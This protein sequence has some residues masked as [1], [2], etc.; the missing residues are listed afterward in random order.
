MQRRNESWFELSESPLGIRANILWNTL[1]NFIYL[2]SQWFLTFCVVAVLGIENMGVFSLAIAITGAVIGISF[3]GVRSFQVSDVKGKYLDQV[4]VL[5]RIIT[6]A[7]SLV[8]CAVFVA[9]NAYSLYVSVC[10]LVYMLFKISESLSDVYQGVFQKTMRMD[11]IGKSFIIKGIAILLLFLATIYL[12]QDLLLGVVALCLCSCV[13]IALYDMRYA[14]KFIQTI[15]ET[16]WVSPTKALLIECLPIAGYTVVF[17]MLSQIPRYFI[18]IQ[19]GMEA[20]GFY[21]T[22]AMPVAIVQV[23]ASFIFAPLTTPF[24]Q[25]LNKGEIASFS[26]LLVKTL[27]FLGAL[28]VVSIIVFALLGEWM[29]IML[30]GEMIAPYTYLLMP[31]VICTILVAV[32]WFLSTLLV[33]LRKQK[34]LLLIAVI[35][36][37]IVLFGSLPLIELFAQ[38]GASIVLI[39]SLSL[40]CINSSIALAI[41]LKKS[42]KTQV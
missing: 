30:F 3:Y 33:V 14:K 2:A 23:S 1:G 16:D 11:Y 37:A 41:C 20:L 17:N 39:V 32:S 10:I 34:T 12:T 26:R 7:I 13:I 38:N 42:A 31:L 27:L 35:S 29:L 25:H 9:F 15:K 8:V 19:M 40:F 22:I 36:L 28:S 21:A 18:E 4:Y 24:A 6:S 5:A